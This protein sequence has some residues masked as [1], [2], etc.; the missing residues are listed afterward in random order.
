MPPVARNFQAAPPPTPLREVQAR[1]ALF[2]WL[3]IALVV[4]AGLV[5]VLSWTVAEVRA[6]I[7]VPSAATHAVGEDKEGKTK[8]GLSSFSSDKVCLCVCLWCAVMLP[9]EFF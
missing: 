3:V 8:A 5:S 6:L 2:G 4:L 7:V 9:S 1:R